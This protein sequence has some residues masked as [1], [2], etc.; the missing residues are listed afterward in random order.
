MQTAIL[1]SDSNTDLKLLIE[2][3]KKIGIKAKILTDYEI[4]NIGLAMAVKEGRTSEHIDT[5]SYLN[6]LRK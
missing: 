6:K 2:L 1:K 4:E 3:A 5:D